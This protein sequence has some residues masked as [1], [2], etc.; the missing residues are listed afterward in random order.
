VGVRVDGER[1][2]NRRGGK[3]RGDG[4]GGKKRKGKRHLDVLQRRSKPVDDLIR[5]EVAPV[6]V[7]SVSRQ[8]RSGN[9]G[10][11]EKSGGRRGKKER[12]NEPFGAGAELDGLLRTTVGGGH[13]IFLCLRERE[14]RPSGK[15]GREGRGWRKRWFDG[16]VR[17]RE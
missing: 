4:E 6:S 2:R 15:G 12:E 5:D 1:R 8:N 16:L 11:N 10:K 3:R 7:E 14:M 17:V 9:K 13:A